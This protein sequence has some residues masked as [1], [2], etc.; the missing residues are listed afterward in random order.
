MY[1]EGNTGPTNAKKRKATGN[2][3]KKSAADIDFKVFL[4]ILPYE[5]QIL[6]TRK[7]HLPFTDLTQLGHS[8]SR[9]RL[10][11]ISFICMRSFCIVP[12]LFSFEVEH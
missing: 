11:F 1:G 9:L 7:P 5:L 8:L 12:S 2:D 6:Y 4:P 10:D 3:D